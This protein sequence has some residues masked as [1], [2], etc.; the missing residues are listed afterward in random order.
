MIR[1]RLLAGRNG[2]RR[3][4]FVGATC[5][6]VAAAL[7]AGLYWVDQRYP[8]YRAWSDLLVGAPEDDPPAGGDGG[9]PPADA[10]GEE[11]TGSEP[12]EEDAQAAREA[13]RQEVA[14]AQAEKSEE[15]V[16]AA[17]PPEEGVVVDETEEPVEPTASAEELVIVDEAEEPV[18][19]AASAEQGEAEQG[20]LR[21]A[22]RLSTVCIQ[23]FRLY[24]RVP[25]G[26]RFT[27]LIS[28][29]TGE[30]TI[31]GS[32]SSQELAEFF[33]DTLKQLP[34]RAELSWLCN[35]GRA[36][37]SYKYKFA[38]HGHFA[39]TDA[40]GLDPL[41]ST[42][43]RSMFRQVASWAKASGL[44][45]VAFDGPIPV[46]S[47]RSLVQQ[48]QKMWASGSYRQIGAFL[49]SFEQAG[50]RA[51]LGEMVVV[52]VGRSSRRA[53]L[54]TAVDVLVR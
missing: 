54:Y 27:A 48:R 42:E 20:D 49:Q 17:V 6:A 51:S 46:A 44:G 52:P 21:R 30:Y 41:S 5:L 14:A 53:R 40:E 28:N 43:A 2:Y 13:P 19:P 18:E 32:S 31:E 45:A 10:A 35:K 3:R 11:R 23:A 50:A 39:A 7:L 37:Q 15:L 12:A 8:L 24:G 4:V 34:L 38:L 25:S 47:L 33:L 26:M 16:E 9:P 36:E 29:A 22:P 1:I